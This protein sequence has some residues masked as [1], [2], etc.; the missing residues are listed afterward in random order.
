[1]GYFEQIALADRFVFLDDVQYTRR[2]WRNR[3]RIRT[4]HGT[5]WLTVPVLARGLDLTINE[6]NID[7]RR[8]WRS[9]H[10]KSIEQSYRKAPFFEEYFV[11]IRRVLEQ[12]WEKISDLDMAL[13]RLF[14]HKLG[15]ETDFALASDVVPDPSRDLTDADTDEARRIRNRNLRIL[16]ICQHHRATTFYEGARGA[17]FLDVEL[18]NAH[19]IAVVFQN[20]QHPVYSQ[21]H[22]GFESHISVIDL[23]MNTG[24]EARKIVLSSP[25]P[26]GLMTA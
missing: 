21:I 24:P 20:Y 26:E 15:I 12:H 1:M 10:L 5:I 19:G 2:D 16:E 8:D 14:A 18:F 22:D 3:N 6:V 13:I 11:E 25:V 17:D 23:L 7:Y 9:K 4:G